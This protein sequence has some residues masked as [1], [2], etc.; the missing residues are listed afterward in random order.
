M[1]EF[2][3]KGAREYYEKI[4]KYCNESNVDLVRKIGKK[5]V[6]RLNEGARKEWRLR[7]K[8]GRNLEGKFA[9]CMC[10][11]GENDKRISKLSKERICIVHKH[12]VEKVNGD[13]HNCE[14]CAKG[15]Y[16]NKHDERYWRIANW[17]KSRKDVEDREMYLN[18]YKR[19]EECKEEYEDFKE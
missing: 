8:N 6:I 7:M 13:W 2:E 1:T 18:V 19:F 3:E 11:M 4:V 9:A 17:M 10:V 12:I 15:W 5:E 14:S 16:E